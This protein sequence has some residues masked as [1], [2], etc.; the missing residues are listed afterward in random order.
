MFSS[1]DNYSVALES[2]SGPL[3]AG[4]PRARDSPDT[5]LFRS[6]NDAQSP[7]THTE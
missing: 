7:R 3:S 2:K 6:L 1:I 4:T 5:I